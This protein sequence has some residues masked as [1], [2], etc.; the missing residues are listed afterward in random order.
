MLTQA[1]IRSAWAPRCRGPWATITLHG[2]GRVSVRPAIVDAVHALNACLRA[3]NYQT[4]Q[5][6]TGAYVCREN[7]S[8]T[9]ASTHAYGIA[10]D[11]NWQSNPYGRRLR[12]NM[13][14][15]MCA[16]ICRIRTNNGAQVWNW[17][18]YWSGSKDAMHF[19]I[20]CRP[21]DLAR[22]INPATVPSG[23]VAPPTY[24]AP[25]PPPAPAPVAPPRVT[26]PPAPLPIPTTIAQRKART[27]QLVHAPNDHR[28]WL[29]DGNTR[30][31]MRSTAEW[32]HW[33]LWMR[34]MGHP[35]PEP[36]QWAAEF[37]GP[38]PVVGDHPTD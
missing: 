23:F 36:V 16:A 1:Q 19:E 29:V 33:S 26:I 18:G 7:T 20:V 32:Q 5:K 34:L 12:T 24:T 37:I 10:L 38:I 28:I 8:G 30:R 4:R 2:A 31:W 25:P 6:D 22:G 3:W 17:G 35:Y 13:P 14:P 27:M 11:L 21:S 9:M 15:A